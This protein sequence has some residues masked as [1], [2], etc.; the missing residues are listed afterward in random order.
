MAICPSPQII[1]DFRAI[2]IPSL[3][4][5]GP[6]HSTKKLHVGHCLTHRYR[7]ALMTLAACRNR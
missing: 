1:R 4:L 6:T 2:G 3:G 7:L 5:V